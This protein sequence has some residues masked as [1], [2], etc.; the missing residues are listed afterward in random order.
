[1][2]SLLP[3]LPM[4]LAPRR[5]RNAPMALA[6]LG[7]AAL[8]SIAA[9]ADIYDDAVAHAGRPAAD[10]PRDPVD[11]PAEILRLAG[12]KPGMRVGDFLAANGYYSELLSYIVGPKGRVLMINNAAYD[13]WSP[14]WPKRIA[15]NRLP[16]VRH[17]TMDIEHLD[18]PDNSLDA[19]LL[20]KVYHDLYVHDLWPNIDPDKA[21][22]EI[23]RVLKPGGVL[24]L[25]DHS[26]RIGSG[27]ADTTALHRIEEA[28]ARRDFGKRGFVVVASSQ[29]LRRPDDPRDQI[30]YQGPMVGKTD[31]FVLVLRK[32]G[33]RATTAL[34]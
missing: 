29:V 16:N 32:Q 24:L 9:R 5:F 10:L 1:M 8:A 34:H 20:V 19:A 25:V 7:L 14:Q 13:H 2:F 22:S 15:A 11:H 18:L 3:E 26:A 28:Y 17:M 23:A 6:L 4:P 30:S 21:V 12:I 33:G 31:R 27:T